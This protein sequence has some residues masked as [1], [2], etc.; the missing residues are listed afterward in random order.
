[1]IDILNIWKTTRELSR[2]MTRAIRLYHA[3]L[4]GDTSLLAEYFPW[5]GTV[6]RHSANGARRQI[7]DPIVEYKAQSEEDQ[8]N[9]AL[10]VGFGGLDL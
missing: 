1:V 2:N 7:S 9:D 8:V 6:S 4:T 3:L 10:D 5:I